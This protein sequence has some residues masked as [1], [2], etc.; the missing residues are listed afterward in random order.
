MT[1]KNETLK[2]TAQYAIHFVMRMFWRG[3]WAKLTLIAVLE[4]IA[5]S[6]LRIDDWTYPKLWHLTAWALWLLICIIVRVVR[7]E[8]YA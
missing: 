5:Q 2:T 8:N 1:I 6:L 4:I 3:V 7:R